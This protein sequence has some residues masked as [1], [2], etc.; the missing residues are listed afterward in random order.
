MEVRYLVIVMMVPLL[1]W[2][3]LAGDVMNFMNV[4]K[5]IWSHTRTQ[6]NRICNPDRPDVCFEAWREI[7]DADFCKRYSPTNKLVTQY[8]AKRKIDCSK[9]GDSTSSKSKGAYPSLAPGKTFRDCADCPEMVVIPA[10]SF[11][12]GDLSGN[13]SSDE[14]PVHEVKIGYSFAAGKYEVTQAE[15]ETVMGKNPS[16]FKGARKPVESV[17]WNDAK[18]YVGKLSAKTGKKYRLLSDSEWEYMARA[19]STSNYPWGNRFD[20]SKANN[21]SQTVPVGSY[22]ANDFGVH[23]T[24]G[25]VD[26]WLEDC[27]HKNYH[28][29]PIDGSAWTSGGDCSKRV[30]RGGSWGIRP[31]FLRSAFRYWNDAAARYIVSG[32]RIARTLSR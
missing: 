15:W 8:L 26:E 17:T 19:G 23:D 12:M 18:A 20:A 27:W 9:L 7:S 29:A 31:R 24:A 1:L 2:G 25:N 21:K 30:L 28:G 6:H 32:F 10:G 22:G 4:N 16:K 11:K 14:K 13:G 5:S 3:C